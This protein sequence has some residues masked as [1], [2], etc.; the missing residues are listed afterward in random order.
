MLT[1]N[2]DIM[3]SARAQLRGEWGIAVGVSFI[4]LVITV[5][6]NVIPVLG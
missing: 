1:A 2:R 5:A 4:Y 6:L 3:T